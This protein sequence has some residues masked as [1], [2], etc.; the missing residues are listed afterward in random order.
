MRLLSGKYAMM[1]L[2][3]FNS[4]EDTLYQ[5]PEWEQAAAMARQLHQR[6]I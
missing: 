5:R 6:G 4:V 3:P 2:I 1:N